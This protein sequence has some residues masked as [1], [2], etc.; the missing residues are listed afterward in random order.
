MTDPA[1]VGAARVGRVMPQN[2]DKIGNRNVRHFRPNCGGVMPADAWPGRE[3][4]I[5]YQYPRGGNGY[6]YYAQPRRYS[7]RVVADAH[8]YPS[9]NIVSA[10]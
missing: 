10:N 9:C 5:P 8:H 7:F 6:P 4:L 1:R 3:Q 2:A